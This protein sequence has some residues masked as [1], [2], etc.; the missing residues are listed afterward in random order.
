MRY[1]GLILVIFVGRIYGQANCDSAKHH[2]KIEIYLV[3]TINADT[4]YGKRWHFEPKKEDLADT[5]FIKDDEITEYTIIGDTIHEIQLRDDIAKR[6]HELGRTPPLF[7][8]YSRYPYWFIYRA[9][10]VVVD[11]EPIYG[12][13]FANRYLSGN[14]FID[15]IRIFTA[16]S[17]KNWNGRLEIDLGWQ[18]DKTLKQYGDIRKSTILLD[19][20][21]QTNRLIVK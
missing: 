21:Q 6:L 2:C 14:L 7:R 9:F 16:Y 19:C 3:N 10:A 15:W 8:S 5:A 13:W 1:L 11:G 4:T 17:D 12:G 20:L 18:Q